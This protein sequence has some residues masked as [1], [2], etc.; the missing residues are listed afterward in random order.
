MPLAPETLESAPKAVALLALASARPPTTVMLLP[1]KTSAP[2]LLS[3]NPVPARAVVPIAIVLEPTATAFA[4]IATAEL[5]PETNGVA[6]PLKRAM[7]LLPIAVALSTA[8]VFTPTATDAN[9]VLVVLGPLALAFWPMAM[10]PAW[11]EV[12]SDPN[13]TAPVAEAALLWPK[14]TADSADACADCPTATALSALEIA[15]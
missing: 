3:A 15:L 7:A 11:L 1:A 9:K 6:V 12:A 2:G 13:A 14:A 4:P 5:I 8:V 10:P